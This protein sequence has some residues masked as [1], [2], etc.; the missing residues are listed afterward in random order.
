MNITIS[1]AFRKFNEK[2]Y[3]YCYG[4]NSFW[5]CNFSIY[6]TLLTNLILSWWEHPGDS[7]YIYWNLLSRWELALHCEMVYWLNVS[8][9]SAYFYRGI[10]LF[11]LHCLSS[12]ISMSPSRRNNVKIINLCSLLFWRVCVFFI[13]ELV[14]SILIL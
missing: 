3:N 8:S 14:S 12:K 9:T 13:S 11:L 4:I 6:R 1:Y 10:C 2:L 7:I 5:N